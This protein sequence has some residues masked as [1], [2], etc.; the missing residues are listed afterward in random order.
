[1]LSTVFYK[2]RINLW[3]CRSWKRCMAFHS[4]Y[5]VASIQHLGAHYTT[6]HLPRHLK[7]HDTLQ[8]MNFGT[9]GHHPESNSSQHTRSDTTIGS[10]WHRRV[11][12]VQKYMTTHTTRHSQF[13]TTHNKWLYKAHNTSQHIMPHS[14]WRHLPHI[15]RRLP[16]NTHHYHSPVCPYSITTQLYNS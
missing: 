6:V 14:T 1:M 4:T 13:T 2:Y 10:A 5:E 8:L 9:S 15:T 3:L 11:H 16:Y 7:T 12:D